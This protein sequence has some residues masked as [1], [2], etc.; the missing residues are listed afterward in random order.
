MAGTFQAQQDI[1]AAQF[2]FTTIFG[3][4]DE[5]GDTKS[6]GF[7]SQQWLSGFFFDIN[8]VSLILERDISQ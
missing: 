8:H 7:W 3:V 2:F 5:T 4:F 1:A 6:L